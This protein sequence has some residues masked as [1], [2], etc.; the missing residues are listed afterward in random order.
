VYLADSLGFLFSQKELMLKP[1]DLQMDQLNELD[2]IH[3][4]VS[5]PIERFFNLPAI[6]TEIAWWQSRALVG[7]DCRIITGEEELHDDGLKIVLGLQHPPVPR[8]TTK[9]LSELRS[10]GVVFMTLAYDKENIYGGGFAT[11]HLPLTD[12]GRRLL[13]DMDRVG[14]VL[15]LS[16]VGRQTARDAIAHIRDGGLCLP[17]VA[18]HSACADVYSHPR[19]IPDD[20]ICEIADLDGFVGVPTCTFMLH[21]SD[22][23]MKP[24][25]RHVQHLVKVAGPD[26]VAIGSDGIY[27]HLS[28]KERRELFQ[29]MK[30]LVDSNNVFRAR[31]PTEHESLNSGRR[32]R[33]IS[34]A[35]KG[36]ISRSAIQGVC[37]ENF[38]RFLSRVL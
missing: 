15:D 4:T 37:G 34:E 19:N 13:D 35:L 8:P 20:I 18:T 36:T 26:A 25:R 5:P 2:L 7:Y 23:S 14:M 1:S 21:D 3:C 22:N 33:V 10:S 31:Y 24:F 32:L 16:H 11:P 6:R 9:E 29:M 12:D 17:V 28:E 30:G 27:K 38:R